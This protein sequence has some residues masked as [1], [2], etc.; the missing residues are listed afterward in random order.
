MQ[1]VQFLDVVAQ[2]KHALEQLPQRAT[3]ESYF[4]LEQLHKEGWED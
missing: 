2:V 1:D 4:E 3:P